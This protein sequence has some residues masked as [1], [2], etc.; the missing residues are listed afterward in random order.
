MNKFARMMARKVLTVIFALFCALGINAQNMQKM[1]EYDFDGALSEYRDSLKTCTDSLRIVAFELAVKRAENGISL[2]EYCHKPKVVT[3]KRFH[4]DEFFL[5]YPLP[6]EAWHDT[7]DPEKT[8]FDLSGVQDTLRLAKRDSLELFPVV[9]G[10]ERYFAAKNLYGMGGYDLYVSHWDEDSNDWGTPQNL[11]FPYSSPYDDFLFINTEDGKFSIFASN[12]DCP[13]DSVNV[14][15]VEYEPNPIRSAV[16]DPAELRKIA[17]LDPPQVKPAKKAPAKE[18]VEDENTRKYREKITSVRSVRDS[19][20]IAGKKLQSLRESYAA[21]AGAEKAR[22]AEALTDGEVNLTILQATLN[23]VSR[24]LR[25]IEMD[26]LVNGVVINAESFA[27]SQ[28]PEEEPAPPQ[29]IFTEHKF[30]D[31]LYVLYL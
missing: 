23:K 28:E 31:P 12:R 3:R 5:Y 6:D 24:E 21:A 14:Y 19:I 4:R 18:K 9:M 13:A 30:G 29:F 22:I 11:G 17:A 15:V 25:D 7:Q 1:L 8:V 27:P 20:A 2:T 10:K 16:T 26:F